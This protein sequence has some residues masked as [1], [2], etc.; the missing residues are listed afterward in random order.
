ME[1][2][3]SVI[4]HDIINNLQRDLTNSVLSLSLVESTR[5]EDKSQLAVFVRDATNYLKLRE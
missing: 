1:K 5:I 4:F 3:I 2:R